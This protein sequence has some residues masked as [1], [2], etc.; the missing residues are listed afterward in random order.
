MTEL[1]HWFIWNDNTM[2]RWSHKCPWKVI[3]SRIFPFPSIYPSCGGEHGEYQILGRSMVGCS[4]LCSQHLDLYKVVP[5]RNLTISMVLGTSH[6]S[7]LNLKFQMQSQ[8]SKKLITSRG[9]CFL[10]TPC[11]SPLPL[12][13]QEVGLCHPHVC[14]RLS[15]FS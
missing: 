9:F 4:T 1:W 2:V 5:M 3:T 14:L 8:G 10:L 11:I 13:I 12:Q 15:L 6:P 7:I